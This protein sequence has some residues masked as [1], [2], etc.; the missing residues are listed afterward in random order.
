MAETKVKK[1]KSAAKVQEELRELSK[2]KEAP[3]PPDAA[4]KKIALRV[5][6]VLVVLWVVA[7]F[8]PFSWAKIVVG[9]L[10]VAVIG[11]GIWVYRLVKK[12][13]AL[14]QLLQGADTDE[15]RKK[16]LEQ[17]QSQFKKDDTQAILARA[18]LEMQEDPRK[19]LAS[20]ESVNL[21]K[22]MTPIADQVRTM[23]AM[24]HLTLGET[25]EARALVDKMQMGKQQDVKQ[26]AL[27]AVVAGEAWGRTGQGKKAIELLDVFNPEDTEL[28]EFRVQ[29]WRARAFAYAGANDMKGAERAL[30]KL[31]EINP[32]LL[33]MFV[34]QKKVH[35]LLQQQAKMLLMKS[36]A[37]PR[38]QVRQ[39][40]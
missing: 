12:Q 22:A 32:H 16:A 37:V 26:R 29:M 7:F 34:Q 36:G 6:I 13:Q 17:L 10:T 2:P 15:G 20:L 5:G 39:R 3:P 31:L 25:Q 11:A 27:F 40:M 38:K 14:G 21:E 8:V 1:K 28:S 35:P 18:Q 19:A 24:I 9:V 30:K 4:I 33:G 23:R